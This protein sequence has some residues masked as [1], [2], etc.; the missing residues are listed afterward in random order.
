MSR[1]RVQGAPC[2][3][4]QLPNVSAFHVE[5]R[6]PSR[7]RAWSLISSR[8]PGCSP[9]PRI[10]PRRG[11]GRLLARRRPDRWQIG[12][13]GA[14]RT[15]GRRRPVRGRAGRTLSAGGGVLVTAVRRRFLGDLA[16]W[17]VPLTRGNRAEPYRVPSARHR[18]AAPRANTRRAGLFHVEPKRSHRRSWSP[19][20][21]L[22]CVGAQHGRT[23]LRSARR[24]LPSAQA[25]F[26]VEHSSNSP[27]CSRVSSTH[28]R[29]LTAEATFG[30][31]AGHR[32]LAARPCAV[33]FHVERR[34]IRTA[35][36]PA[37]L[38]SSQR[39]PVAAPPTAGRGNPSAQRPS[40]VPGYGAD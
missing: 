1:S 31:R 14:G 25:E 11:R 27:G 22:I 26:H 12:G 23:R 4:G 3:G 8:Q 17:P 13:S 5:P 30:R 34:M 39:A 36:R 20:D 29:E 7:T 38:P 40:V 32:R 28:D 37:A 15:G 19:A 18:G 16:P 21:I 33:G 2:G 24:A 10:G 9:P 6:A 35:S